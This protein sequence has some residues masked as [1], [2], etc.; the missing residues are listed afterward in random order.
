MTEDVRSDLKINGINAVSMLCLLSQL[1]FDFEGSFDTIDIAII[2]SVFCLSLSN[3]IPKTPILDFRKRSFSIGLHYKCGFG[4]RLLL[5][6]TVNKLGRDRYGPFRRFRFQ[7]CADD[8]IIPDEPY[9]TAY[10]Y[11]RF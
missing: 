9:R 10:I 11:Q 4:D 7:S 5:L 2:Y 3:E 6:Q 1:G 8:W